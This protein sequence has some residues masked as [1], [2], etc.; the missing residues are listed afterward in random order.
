MKRAAVRLAILAGLFFAQGCAGKSPPLQFVDPEEFARGNECMIKGDWADAVKNYDRVIELD[1]NY[2]VAFNNRGAAHYL[3]GEYEEAAADF[4]EAVSILVMLA[5]AWNNLAY[6]EQR[7]GR[8]RAAA[9]DHSR[10]ALL[11]GRFASA[12]YGRGLAYYQLGD[13][14]RAAADFKT[15]EELPEEDGEPWGPAAAAVLYVRGSADQQMEDCL[16]AGGRE[17]TRIEPHGGALWA[18]THYRYPADCC[19]DFDQAFVLLPGGPGPGPLREKAL[20]ELGKAAP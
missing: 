3:M 2:A 20:G 8:W 13:F 15:A 10:A 6:A 5:P 11:N 18:V 17:L 9:D 19:Y 16:A 12:Y 1:P 7:L 4:G 14:K